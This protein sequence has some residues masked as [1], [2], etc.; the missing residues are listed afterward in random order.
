LPTPAPVAGLG[1]TLSDLTPALAN[2]YNVAADTHG[3]IIT[4]V[5]PNSIAARQGLAAGEV[6][7]QLG[8]EPV[9]NMREFL[10]QEVLMLVQ[11]SD[12]TQW[13][14]LNAGWSG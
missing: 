5:T 13:I 14:S 1:L 9:P 10:N 3:V 4:G 7:L 6:V 8:G 12:E 11:G 2:K